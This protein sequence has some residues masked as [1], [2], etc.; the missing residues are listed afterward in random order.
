MK[1][2]QILQNCYRKMNLTGIFN[3]R[4]TNLDICASLKKEA[5]FKGSIIDKM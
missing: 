2:A 4:S 5:S 3:E 1:K